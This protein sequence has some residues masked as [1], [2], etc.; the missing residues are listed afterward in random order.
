MDS[1]KSENSGFALVMA[2]WLFALLAAVLAS[3]LLKVRSENLIAANLSMNTK[4]EAIADGIVRSVAFELA[5]RPSVA[6][7]LYRRCTWSANYFVEIS[8]QD[9]AGLIDL[10]TAPKDILALTIAS[11]SGSAAIAEGIESYRDN[12]SLN[13][14]GSPESARYQGKDYGPK[15]APFLVI[16]ELQQVPGVDLALY[17]RLSEMVTVHSFE[18]GLDQN[19]SPATLRD[20]II[21][22]TQGVFNSYR[23]TSKS[24]SVMIDV[25]VTDIVGRSKFRRKAIAALHRRPKHP[26]GFLTWQRDVKW[27]PKF[28]PTGFDADCIGAR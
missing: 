8:V 19:Q 21:S 20:I 6:S 12:D 27:G 23:A 24:F 13:D 4:V 9:Q 3:F 1:E 16:E 7:G 22:D 5:L 18:N 14:D 2:V 17:D 11:L 25:R 10:N 26:F 15:N 28:P